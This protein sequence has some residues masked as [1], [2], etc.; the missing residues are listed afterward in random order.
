MSEKIDL[1]A[2]YS[3]KVREHF[4]NPKNRG[5]M[6]DADC[7]AVSKAVCG[8][9]TEIFLKIKDD[10]I[11]DVKFQTTGCIMSVAT[12]SALTEMVKGKTLDEAIGIQEEDLTKEVG[13]V[14]DF[15]THCIRNS[16]KSL[17]DAI[18]EYRRK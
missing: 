10:K 11:I 18:A 3:D 4:K 1:F 6:E 15:K 5:K 16:L 7:H 17:R 13:G 8:D 2:N 9:V 14:P 12:A